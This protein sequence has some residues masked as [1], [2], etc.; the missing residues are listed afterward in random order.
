MFG[1]HY[2]YFHMGSFGSEG[3]IFPVSEWLMITLIL[4]EITVAVLYLT[5]LSEDQIKK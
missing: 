3:Y 4:I 1:L 2:E 5:Q